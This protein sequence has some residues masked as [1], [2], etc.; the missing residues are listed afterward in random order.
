MSLNVGQTQSSSATSQ[1]SA[2][3]AAVATAPTV[4]QQQFLQLL[5]AQL[6]HQDPTQPLQGTEFVTQLAQFSLVEQ[7]V[8]Q[9]QQLSGLST[10]LTGMSNDQTTQLV[11]QNVTISGSSISLSGG[12]A[13][14]ANVTLA[15]PAA[16]VTAQITDANGNVVQTLNLGPHAAGLMTVSWNGNTSTGQAAPNG[17]Y[18]INVTA[19]DPNGGQVNVSQNVSGVVANVS[20]SQGY[21]QITLASGAQAPISSLVSVGAA[22][23]TP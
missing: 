17:T 9:T 8:A 19:T 12:T 7:S 2:T 1:A 13:S 23:T 4:N 22:T 10:Q 16:D 11:G 3:T 6:Q 20:F 14:P 5:V 21:P 15:G 18:S